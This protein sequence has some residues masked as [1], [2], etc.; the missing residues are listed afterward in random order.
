M[1]Q[2]SNCIGMET[3]IFICTEKPCL[4]GQCVFP[5]GHAA[6]THLPR[7]RSLMVAMLRQQL[8]GR[9]LLVGNMVMLPVLGHD[10]VFAVEAIEGGSA[11]GEVPAPL[12]LHCKVEVLP[13]VSDPLETKAG[14]SSSQIFA[15]AAR[16]AV[17]QMIQDEGSAA[18]AAFKAATLGEISLGLPLDSI[19]GYIEHIAALMELVVKPLQEPEVYRRYNISPP[20]GV[21]LHGPPGKD[22]VMEFPYTLMLLRLQFSVTFNI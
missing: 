17:A 13:Y 22:G 1:C 3:F 21:L 6:E 11:G 4:T 12:A 9:R 2:G 7:L 18:Y 10:V 14:E 5:L 16:A 8:T 20:R 19:G 15:Q